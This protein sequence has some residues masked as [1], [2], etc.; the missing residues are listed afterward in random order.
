MFP[1]SF[2]RLKFDDIFRIAFDNLKLKTVC[3]SS[4]KPNKPTHSKVTF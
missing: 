1:C 2:K 3:T 4:Y